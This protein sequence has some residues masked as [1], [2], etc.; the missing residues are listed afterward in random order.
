MADEENY[1]SV[2]TFTAGQIKKYM[3]VI[4]KLRQNK[5][6][7][8]KKKVGLTNTI[9]FLNLI[10]NADKEK[11]KKPTRSLLKTNSYNYP[12]LIKDADINKIW[13][14]TKLKTSGSRK[15]L[16]GDMNKVYKQLYG[17]N[18]LEPA[19]PAKKLPKKKRGDVIVSAP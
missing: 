3:K 18:L 11:Q 4:K 16:V 8:R 14:S 17:F 6:T 13:N 7:K 12:S 19:L 10:Y 2:G 9:Q 15:T 1:I 5:K